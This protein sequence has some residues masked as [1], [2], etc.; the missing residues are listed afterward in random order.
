MITP[1][2]NGAIHGAA[3]GCVIDTV[4]PL[5][6]RRRTVRSPTFA[7]VLAAG[8]WHPRYAHVLVLAVSGLHALALIDTNGDG[9][10]IH[11]DHLHHHR[12]HHRG[13]TWDTDL[14]SGP[15]PDH[16]DGML[17][18]GEHQRRAYA[19]G[20]AH[21]AGELAVEVQPGRWVDVTAAA[22]AGWWAWIDTHP[23]AAAQNS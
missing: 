13:G 12:L 21:D 4:G 3:H 11:L 1:P 8:A 14:S 5:T 18:C 7:Q 22:A 10:E 20:H 2:V 6:T 17:G 19:Y 23:I 9:R 15:I 16:T